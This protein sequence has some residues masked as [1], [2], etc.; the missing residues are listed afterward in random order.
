MDGH[1]HRWR[2]DEVHGPTSL[3]VCSGCGACRTFKNWLPE[4]DG[5]SLKERAAPSAA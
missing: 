5:Y 4:L 2:I 3:G 1:I